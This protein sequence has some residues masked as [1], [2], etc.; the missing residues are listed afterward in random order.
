MLDGWHS[1]QR[2]LTAW[3]R[4]DSENSKNS[5][6]LAPIEQDPLAM[7][8]S[9]GYTFSPYA[10]AGL[11]PNDNG[12]LQYWPILRKHRWTILATIIIVVTISTI[13]T[14][15]TTPIYDASGRIAVGRENNDILGFKSSGEGLNADYYDY[16]YAVAL[17]TQVKILQSDAFARRWI[18]TKGALKAD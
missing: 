4:M 9:F 2:A 16:D 13:I 17:D 14:L 12:I 10:A 3:V 11:P 6:G 5:T 8:R 18:K 15:R 1:R 7:G